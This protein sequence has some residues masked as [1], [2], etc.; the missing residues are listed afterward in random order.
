MGGISHV[1]SHSGMMFYVASREETK[2]ASRVLH[3]DC[4]VTFQFVSREETERAS[5]MFNSDSGVTFYVVSRVLNFECDARYLCIVR[6][7]HGR[8]WPSVSLSLGQPTMRLAALSRT[9]LSL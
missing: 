7:L 8:W 4:D 9:P 2:R 5:R 1:Y 6:S 3:S